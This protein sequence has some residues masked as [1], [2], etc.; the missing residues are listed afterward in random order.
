MLFNKKKTR[1]KIILV[2]TLSLSHPEAAVFAK[3]LSAIDVYA[4]NNEKDDIP[5]RP[6][7]SGGKMKATKFLVE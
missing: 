2:A 4:H 1:E 7:C 5:V 3:K 6:P